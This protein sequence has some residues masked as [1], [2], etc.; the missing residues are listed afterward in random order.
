MW[1]FL[2][3]YAKQTHTQQTSDIIGTRYNLFVLGNEFDFISLYVNF[4]LS[5]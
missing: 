3:N 1:L 2:L 5:L 4:K